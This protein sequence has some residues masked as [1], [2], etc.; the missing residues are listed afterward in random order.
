MIFKE[1]KII[2][3]LD[4][5]IDAKNLKIEKQLVNRFLNKAELTISYIIL[6]NDLTI[7]YELCKDII[8]IIKNYTGK[9]KLGKKE[10]INIIEKK[11]EFK[12]SFIYLE[13][14]LDIIKNYF[15]FNLTSNLSNYFIPT[16]G[17]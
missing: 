1:T 15:K 6:K 14:L 7:A 3:N 2:N 17:L 11:E 16:L 12:I 9:V 13:F 8:E 5:V 10:L 4:K